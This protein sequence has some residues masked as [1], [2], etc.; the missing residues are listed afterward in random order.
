MFH[1]INLC[2]CIFF[3]LK[4]YVQSKFLELV[5]LV[6]RSMHNV[7]LLHVLKFLSIEK[8]TVLH[9]FSKVW[10]NLCPHRLSNRE[11]CQAFEFLSISWEY[12]CNFNLHFTYYKWNWHII[13]CLRAIFISSFCELSMFYPFPIVFCV[14]PHC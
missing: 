9:S 7:F 11:S 2:I 1:W 10:E 4:V 8:C 5:L 12:Q 6:E 3:L 13:T 14:F